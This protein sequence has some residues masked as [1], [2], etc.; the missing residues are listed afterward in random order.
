MGLKA[1]RGMHG[2]VDWLCIH[3]NADGTIGHISGRAGEGHTDRSKM[4][5]RSILFGP[6]SPGVSSGP[7][8]RGSVV[9][10][11][12][13]VGF[14]TQEFVNLSGNVRGD[15]WKNLYCAQVLPELCRVGRPQKN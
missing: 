15:L 13:T 6:R 1:S 8:G 5:N 10:V 12:F 11:F 3:Q 7:G 14:V 2:F 4:T 9:V